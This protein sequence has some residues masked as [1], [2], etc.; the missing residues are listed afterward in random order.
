MNT[1]NGH[2]PAILPIPTPKPIPAR[3]VLLSVKEVATILGFTP[4]TIWRWV[5]EGIFP[6]PLH[7][8]TGDKA[9]RWHR[10]T[11][12]RIAREGMQPPSAA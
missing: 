3:R 1:R 11:I 8:G 7:F 10:G 5:A 12:E 4:R 6:K 9:R 2:H